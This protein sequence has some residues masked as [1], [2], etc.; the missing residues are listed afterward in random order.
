MAAIEDALRPH[1]EGGEHDDFA[2]EQNRPDVLRKH[3]PEHVSQADYDRYL[4]LGRELLGLARGAP[5][6]LARALCVVEGGPTPPET[7]VLARG[8]PRSPGARVGP[9]FPSVLTTEAPVL[10]EPPSDATSSGRRRV[11]A[12]WVASPANPLTA[13]VM[14]NRV[15]GHH[16]GRGLVRT[17]SDFGYRG[18]PPTHPEL[19]DWLSAEF[20]ERGWDLKAL[21]RLIV[22]S[23]AYKRS[24]RPDPTALAQDPENDFFWRF[25]LR[26]LSAE[27]VR[28]SVLFAAGRLRLD[29]VGGPSIFPTIQP[30]VL[31]TQSMPGVGWRVSPPEERDRR[32]VYVHI[33]RSLGL[34]ILAAF[35]AA[36]V[37]AS[38]PA[39]FATTQP[40]Q[41]LA[42]L[43]GDFLNEAAADFA[44]DVR[45]QAGVDPQ[46]QVR[47]AL[48]RVTQREPDAA[49][50]RRGVAFLDRLRNVHEM[51]QS[52]AL[53]AF[54]LLALNLNESL[55]LD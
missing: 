40:T 7:F 37:D 22:T 47:T 13:R 28:D 36:D 49:E 5:R 25:D 29:R 4:A 24:S 55:Y 11:L 35:D 6:S 23:D 20:V 43:N 44:A 27:E 30:E 50:V 32:S 19:L 21:H 51:A 33:K 34:P 3:V 16:F 38:C 2:Y 14:V 12:D 15:W 48:R 39:R 46:A 9:G 52:D 54:C 10:P 8:D 31:K 53:R 18:A 42:M 17:P 41:A 1:L 45:R 26:R